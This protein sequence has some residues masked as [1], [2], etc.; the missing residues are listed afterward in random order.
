VKITRGFFVI[1]ALSA[2][3]SAALFYLFRAYPMMPLAAS[4]EAFHVDHAFNIV[5]WLSIPIYS[6][7]MAALIYALFVFRSKENQDEGEKFAESRGHWVETLWIVASLVITI[8]LAAFGSIELRKLHLSQKQ[9]DL[10]INVNASQFSWEFY[11]PVQAQY[12]ARLVLPVGKKARLIFKS[13]DVIHSFWVPEFRLKQ[14]VL[15]G[16]VTQIVITPTLLGSYELRCAELCG[17]DHT[18]MTAMVDVVDEQE[19]HNRLE[20]ESW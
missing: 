14:D 17:Q 10:E 18:V 12:S 20:G 11:Y 9:A 4:A 1:I 3:F 7:V 13:A 6:L 16:K 8:G 5:L 19:F 15:P 2:I